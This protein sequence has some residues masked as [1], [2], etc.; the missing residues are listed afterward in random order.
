MAAI[1]KAVSRQRVT[2]SSPDLYRR[3][4]YIKTQRR[5]D[6]YESPTSKD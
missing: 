5:Q 6:N 4:K 2:N 3:K 1:Y